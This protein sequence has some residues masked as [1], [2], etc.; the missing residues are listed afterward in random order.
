[1]MISVRRPAVRALTAAVATALVSIANV[2]FA[3]HYDVFVTGN[4]TN[5]VVGGFDDGLGTAFV[6][7]GQLRVFEGEVTGNLTANMTYESEAPGDPGF[8]A[9][10]QTFLNNP[11]TMTPDNVYT[12]LAA[13]TNLNFSFLPFTIGANS[14]N[15]FFWD[16]LGAVDFAPVGSSI[17]VGLTKPGVGGYTESIDG[18]DNAVIAGNTIQTTTGVGAVHTHLFASID[19]GGGAPDQ[20]FYLFSLQLEMAGY[21]SSDSLYFVYGALDPFDIQNGQTLMDF[22]AAHGDAATWVQDNLV[23]PVP[24][25]STYALIGGLA[26]VGIPLVR[27]LR[28]R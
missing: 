16:G 1:M 25:P 26:M 20:G 28:R 22:E 17:V 18:S 19:D 15:L 27:R 13:S 21:S 3:Q 10:N 11:A 7:A 2:A 14:R 12:A 6:P 23:A 24:E 5:L 4:G 8:R 9:S